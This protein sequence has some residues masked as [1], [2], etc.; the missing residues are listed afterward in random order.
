MSTSVTV[1]HFHDVIVRITGSVVHG[2][3]RNAVL[4]RI[5]YGITALMTKIKLYVYDNK[6]NSPYL[7]K[8]DVL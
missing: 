4:K 2:R 1:P 8:T 5:V 6:L 7:I 3:C